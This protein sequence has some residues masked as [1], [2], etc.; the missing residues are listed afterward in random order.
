MKK[1]EI[2]IVLLVDF[3]IDNNNKIDNLVE[4]IIEDGKKESYEY[5]NAKVYL[6]ALKIDGNPRMLYSDDVDLDNFIWDNAHDGAA[7]YFL[8]FNRLLDHL[9]KDSLKA[10]NR[11]VLIL[12]SDGKISNFNY[13]PFKE[14]KT[15]SK[16]EK[17]VISD[18]VDAKNNEFFLSFSI[19]ESHI[20]NDYNSSFWEIFFILQVDVAKTSDSSFLEYCMRDDAHYSLDLEEMEMQCMI[21]EAL[22]GNREYRAKRSSLIRNHKHIVG[23]KKL[24]DKRI[25]EKM[26]L[27]DKVSEQQSLLQPR[28]PKSNGKESKT[29][30]KKSEVGF[31]AYV[32]RE[33]EKGDYSTI[34]IFMYQ[35]KVKKEI[36]RII[37]ENNEDVKE[38]LG[39]KHTIRKNQK[40]TI[41]LAS[42]DIYIE[43][44]CNAQVWTKG[45]LNFSYNIMVPI[46][47][48][49]NQISFTAS[50]F[51]DSA[52]VTKLRFS[53]N[54]LV[55]NAQIIPVLKKDIRRVF[56][57][58]ASK[59]RKEVVNIIMGM[60]KAAPNQ[61]I[62][63]DVDSLRSGE[64][65]EKRIFKEIDN[66]DVLYLC[67]SPAAKE[68][69]YVNMEWQYGF[70]KHGADFIDPV[71]LVDPSICPPP[72]KLKNKHF[73]DHWLL[74]K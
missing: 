51:F 70:E 26:K 67:W 23:K 30:G 29:R 16:T 73:F 31:S 69:E 36:D 45:Y 49:K 25:V 52:F 42:D 64:D 33:V 11:I 74:Y 13:A 56:V 72:E 21:D 43:D 9:N 57:S 27:I 17:Y 32:P 3:G 5:K 12:I 47:Y 4:K 15:F 71:P 62:F 68:S 66:S 28:L 10:R 37:K 35:D 50:V 6:N 61:E 55:P 7:N 24:L 53:I 48:E 63:L 54:C 41:Y 20:I 46:E 18:S 19:D 60:K 65:W 40:V 8:G 58:Y 14:D 1:E 34:N 59:D 39:G 2:S 22:L 38:I 44:N